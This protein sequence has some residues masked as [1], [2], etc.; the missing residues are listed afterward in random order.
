M[1]TEEFI[2]KLTLYSEYGKV[3]YDILSKFLMNELDMKRILKFELAE[4]AEYTN[5]NINEIYYNSD[6]GVV[7][8]LES[9]SSNGEVYNFKL[10]AEIQTNKTKINISNYSYFDSDGGHMRANLS[11]DD[12]SALNDLYK[13]NEFE[14]VKLW[15]IGYE[16]FLFDDGSTIYTYLAKE[17]KGTFNS[18][19]IDI[20]DIMLYKL[21]LDKYLEGTM[22]VWYEDYSGSFMK[23]LLH[24]ND[25]NDG[26]DEIHFDPYTQLNGDYKK[27]FAML[28][29][30]E[31][32]MSYKNTIRD[33]LGIK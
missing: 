22:E 1:K 12:I 5:G 30:Q 18:A 2:N 11:F 8:M 10:R 32:M 13:S 20:L 9:D 25:D 15:T 3:T 17:L 21:V 4:S 26:D 33:A 29:D 28:T 31:T 27:Y 7:I 24:G 6:F 19:D 16:E 23:W 14:F